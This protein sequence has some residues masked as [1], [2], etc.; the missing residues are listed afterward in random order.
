MSPTVP[1]ALKAL[2]YRARYHLS[3]EVVT[4]ELDGARRRFLASSYPEFRRFQSLMGEDAVL[5]AQ[6]SDLEPDDVFFDVGANVGTY[7]CFAAGRLDGGRVVAFEPEPANAARLEANADRN[8]LDV[9]VRRIALSDA[10]GTAHLERAGTAPGAGEHALA[11]GASDRTI[12]VAQR[13]GDGLVEAGAVPVPTVVKIDVEGAELKV[14]E[15]L[16][17]TLA[18][19]ACRLVYCEVHPDRLRAFGGD[20]DD[21]EALLTAAGFEVTTLARLGEKHF[22]RAEAADGH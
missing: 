10:D 14:L 19:D 15:G 3:D 16:A 22:L 11:D 7:A 2:Y 6:L 9:D 4:Y 20:V 12:E 8:G 21:L 5:R 17:E 13:T 1:T 18:R